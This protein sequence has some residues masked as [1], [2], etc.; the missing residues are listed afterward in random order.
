MEGF[1]VMPALEAAERG[2]VFV[3]VTGSRDVLGAEHFERMKDG[4]VLAN[5]GHFDVEIDLAALRG[6]APA[7][8]REVLPL[9]DAVR[10]RRPAAEPARLGPR[11]QPRRRPGPSRRGHGHVVRQPGARGRAPRRATARE[12]GAGRAP[13]AR[14]DRPRGR[15]AQARVARRRDRRAD[16]PSRSSTCAAGAPGSIAAPYERR[17]GCG[18][19]SRRWS[20]RACRRPP[21]AT[22]R[23][24]YEQL[25][26]GRDR[27]A[28][29]VR[30]RAGHRRC[31]TPTALPEGDAPLDRGR[32]HQAQRRARDVHGHD[33]A[34]SLLEVKDGLAFLDVI[35]EQVL[36]LRQATG[37]RLPLVLM[38]SFATRDD[39][40]ALLERHPEIAAD[41]PPD[42]VQNKEPKLLVDGL[43]PGRV[44]GRPGARVVPARARRPLHG[45]AD[46]GDARRAARA[47]LPLRVRLELGQPRRRARPADPR[48]VRGRGDP[49]RG[50][51]H[52]PH[53]G[54]PQGRPPRPRQGDGRAGA[55]RDGA[56]AGGG[57][58]RRSPDIGRHPFFH[59]NNLWVDLHALRDLLRRAR[60][61]ARAADDRQR[62]TV[63][64]SRLLARRPSSSS[65]PRWARR[66]A[67]SRARRRSA[68]RGRASCR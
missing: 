16:A 33:R 42:F 52:R 35:V 53:G 66:S 61:R 65:R 58:R 55:A 30:D 67:C 15:A 57:P 22:F 63:D 60:R 64:P 20:A 43:R 48:L 26:G 14:R 32:G 1:E 25:E 29:R 45:A 56:D 8:A 54:R 11:R 9:V 59:V 7:S 41:V 21:I 18:R 4:A 34:K 31:R 10:P 3:T 2:D 68:C 38:N 36:A 39:S 37:A 27:D 13:G 50:R 44:A 19:A 12:L 49:V 40:L 51:G 5:A 62:K 46:L 28:A 23:H 24:Y 47:R 17:R 6:A